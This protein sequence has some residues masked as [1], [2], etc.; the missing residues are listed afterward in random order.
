MGMVV[1]DWDQRDERIR[2]ITPYNLDAGQKHDYLE[3]RAWEE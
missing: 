1:F 3:R 2:V